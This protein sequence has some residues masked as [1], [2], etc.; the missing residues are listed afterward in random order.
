MRLL[1]I[2]NKRH[3]YTLSR[4]EEI[5]GWKAPAVG[6][7]TR[8]SL[9]L[10]RKRIDAAAR[11]AISRELRHGR[12]EIVS[13][14]IGSRRLGRRGLAEPAV[15]PDATD[16]VESTGA[17]D[18]RAMAAMAFTATVGLRT[19]IR[20]RDCAANSAFT[21]ST[22][23]SFA[24]SP[25]GGQKRSLPAR[26]KT[27]RAL[28]ALMAASRIVLANVDA[29][30]SVLHRSAA[31]SDCLHGRSEG[32]QRDPVSSRACQTL[33]RR[34]RAWRRSHARDRIVLVDP[35]ASVYRDLSQDVS[36]L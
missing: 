22:G 13:V 27:A 26:A 29:H 2:R 33:K 23:P 35:K 3:A 34:V 16:R 31:R 20:P 4:Y 15:V 9:P 18:M 6:G 5:T 30:R 25:P 28:R 10:A 17:N 11:T 32:L 24:S 36:S 8:C 12:I 1:R 21:G 14:Y 7:P 19:L